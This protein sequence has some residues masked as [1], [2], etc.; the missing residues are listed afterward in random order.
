M[1]KRLYVGN[2]PYSS[3]TDAA[4]IDLF[5]PHKPVESKVVVDRDTQRPRGFCFVE[6]ATDEEA[7]DVIAEFNGR[8]VDGRRIIVN[9]AEDKP[10]GGGRRPE[11][12]G[13]GRGRRDGW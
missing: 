12:D 10:R 1:G 5:A 7:H 11:R 9:E 13:R 6:F 2:L 4:L 3:C 8:D